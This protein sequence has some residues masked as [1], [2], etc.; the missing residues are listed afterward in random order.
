MTISSLMSVLSKDVKG[1]WKDEVHEE[2]GGDDLVGM[3]KQKGIDIMKENMKDI[4]QDIYDGGGVGRR[5]QHGAQ[6]EDAEGGQAGGHVV[7][8][9]A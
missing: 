7:L 5:H 9:E 2:D 1:E 4:E 8:R 6:R 3:N